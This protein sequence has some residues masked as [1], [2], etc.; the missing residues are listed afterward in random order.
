MTLAK[1]KR[2]L[3]HFWDTDAAGCVAIGGLCVLALV[4]LSAASAGYAAIIYH[5]SPVGV[6]GS[7]LLGIILSL[8][9]VPAILFVVAIG[10]SV[11][12]AVQWC[13]LTWASSIR[14]SLHAA[15]GYVEENQ[16]DEEKQ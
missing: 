4:I 6:V 13:G 15:N 8:I 3:R 1:T 10:L 14:A 16:A 5:Q 11:V 12:A 2:C 7:V 9:T